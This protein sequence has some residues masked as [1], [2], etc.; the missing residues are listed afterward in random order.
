MSEQARRELLESARQR[1]QEQGRRG[2]R[3]Q[4]PRPRRPEQQIREYRAALRRVTSALEREVRDRVF[5]Q[6]DS[7]L[8]EAGTRDDGVRTDDWGARLAD[9]F[10]ASRA[11][12]GPQIDEAERRMESLGDEVEERA[13]DEQI[14]AIRA[15]MGV[16]PTFYDDDQVRGIVNAWKR[17][18]GAFITNLSDESVQQMMDE[19][20]RAVRS[21]RTN[22]EIRDGLRKRFGISDRRAR[23]IA[24]TEISQLNAQITRERQR[25]LGIE[26]YYWMTSGDERVRD[27]HD[28]REGEFFEWDNPPDDG[29]PGEAVMCRCTSRA[30]IDRLLDQLESE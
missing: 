4:P 6:I 9:L 29:H 24:R 22:R 26:G 5:P 11:A 8:A 10:M 20:S 15:T 19:A 13:T 16:R 7:L 23:T 2:L 3:R 12:L 1:Q 17:E 25:E 27:E 14:R 21:G 28:A 30:A 18:N